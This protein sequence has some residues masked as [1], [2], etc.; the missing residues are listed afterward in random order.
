MKRVL[1]EISLIAVYLVGMPLK[2]LDGLVRAQS[3]HVNAFVSTAGGEAVVSLPINIESW[4]IV[5]SKLLLVT[6]GG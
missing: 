1:V 4:S 2:R 3:A 6:S 5:K